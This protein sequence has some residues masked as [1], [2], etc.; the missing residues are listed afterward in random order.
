[1]TKRDAKKVKVGSELIIK[2]SGERFTV[3]SI[4]AEHEDPRAAVP[5]FLGQ[6]GGGPV[7]YRLCEFVPQ[8]PSDA[9]MKH[10]QSRN[11]G[12]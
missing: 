7:T 3:T 6:A 12:R 9:W 2:M 5:L 10:E 11:A 1:M 8:L 4:Q